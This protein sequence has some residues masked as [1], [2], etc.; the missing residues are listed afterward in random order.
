M[1]NLGI[2]IFGIV[3]STY[4]GI[5]E[6]WILWAEWK[7]G[8]AGIRYIDANMS[9]QLNRYFKLST[10]R[11]IRLDSITS[12]WSCSFW[13]ASL[14]PIPL[15]CLRRQ[16]MQSNAAFAN[17]KVL[18][19]DRKTLKTSKSGADSTD[20][21]LPTDATRSA[22]NNGRHPERI[23]VRLVSTNSQIQLTIWLEYRRDRLINIDKIRF[24]LS[25]VIYLILDISVA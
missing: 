18:S 12:I 16:S 24:D 3:E 19:V 13:W 7:I 9:L 1:S 23:S 25:N 21:E 5:V 11:L 8:Q 4:W 20:S 15:T 14:S 22:P 10:Q 2:S 17:T 6:T